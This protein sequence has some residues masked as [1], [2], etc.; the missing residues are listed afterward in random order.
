MCKNERSELEAASILELE[1]NATPHDLAAFLM[2]FFS[3]SNIEPT[4]Q[5]IGS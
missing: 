5:A 3:D 4:R 2:L 1:K